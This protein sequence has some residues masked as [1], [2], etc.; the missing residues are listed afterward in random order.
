LDLQAS[1]LAFGSFALIADSNRFRAGFL[2]VRFSGFRAF[3]LMFSGVRMKKTSFP[4]SYVSFQ[5]A[6]QSGRLELVEP[7]KAVHVAA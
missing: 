7:R 4:V 6:F 3:F 1:G 2:R 5:Q